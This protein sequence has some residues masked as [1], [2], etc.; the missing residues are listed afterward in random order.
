[1]NMKFNEILARFLDRSGMSKSEL[2]NKLDI[3]PEYIIN[4]I[5]GK[6]RRPPTIDRCREISRALSLSLTETQALIDSAVEERLAPDELIWLTEREK[7]HAKT[8]SI[9]TDEILEAL[10]DPVAV[11]ALL[12]THKN[13]EE[14][15]R[16]IQSVIENMANLSKDKRQAILDLC[17]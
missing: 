15:K 5:G 7:K 6:S 4:I 9:C 8:K 2:A 14:V 17:R 10:A 16:A 13:K 1:M 3:T 12:M 11:K